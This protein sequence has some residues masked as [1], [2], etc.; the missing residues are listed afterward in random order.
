MV[1][2]EPGAAGVL[3]E[4]VVVEGVGGVV[5]AAGVGRTGWVWRCITLSS[6][7]ICLP[8]VV[9]SKP[10]VTWPSMSSSTAGAMAILAESPGWLGGVKLSPARN[11]RATMGAAPWLLERTCTQLSALKRSVMR[12]TSVGESTTGGGGGVG[13]TMGTCTGVGRVTVEV[14]S[15]LPLAARPGT[16]RGG[17]SAAVPSRAARSSRGGT[18]G[19]ASTVR[20]DGLDQFDQPI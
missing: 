16:A 20:F 6:C 8:G 18:A 14:G 4:G 13:T 3:A 19:M 17:G 11:T 1:G 7:R 12:L 9:F 15:A 10:A 5:V 2:A